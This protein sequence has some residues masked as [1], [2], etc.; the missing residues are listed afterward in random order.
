MFSRK[1]HY[2]MSPFIM[3]FFAYLGNC[4]TSAAGPTA[5][6]SLASSPPFATMRSCA[7]VC[8][9]YEGVWSC[10]NKGY[11]DLGIELS[12]GCS[13]Q[14]SCYCDSKAAA[15]ASAYISS[16]VNSGCGAEFPGEVTSAVDLYNGYC[17]TANVAATFPTSAPGVTPSTTATK[18][19][20]VA[21][22]PNTNLDANANDS[23]STTTNLIIGQTSPPATSTTTSEKKGLAQ[24]DVIA[25][26]VGLGVGLPS[27]LLALATF[28]LQRKRRDKANRVTTEIHYVK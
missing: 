26:A 25:L 13:P 8:L 7:R 22:S 12:C 19:T 1:P 2:Q 6:I 24:S 3:L 15:S 16:C 27:L 14:N 11:Y 21:N 18:S 23:S 17:A 28:C 10:S 4:A 5:Y 9:V 20:L